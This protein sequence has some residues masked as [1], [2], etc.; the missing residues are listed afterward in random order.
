M[1]NLDVGRATVVDKRRRGW[2]ICRAVVFFL[3]ILSDVGCR[4]SKL[5]ED[6]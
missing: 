3:A 2:G 6:N 4:D 1:P 5:L